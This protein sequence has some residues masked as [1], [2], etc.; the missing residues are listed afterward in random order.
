MAPWLIGNHLTSET[1]NL[2]SGQSPLATFSVREFPDWS[3]RRLSVFHPLP[4]AVR[5]EGISSGSTYKTIPAVTLSQYWIFPR[6]YPVSVQV[7]V[8][9]K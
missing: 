7:S 5:T 6:Q 9:H 1:V 3:F 8:P 2:Q 4:D